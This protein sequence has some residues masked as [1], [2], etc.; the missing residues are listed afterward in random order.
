MNPQI[1][2]FTFFVMM[3]YATGSALKLD[4]AASPPSWGNGTHFHGVIDDQWNKSDSDQFANHHARTAAANLNVGEPYTVRV[5]YFI[6]NDREPGPNMDAKLDRLIKEIQQF[7]ADQM[8]A[9]GVGR[10]TFRFEADNAGNVVVHRVNGKYNDAYYQNPSTGSWIVWK[11]IEAQFDL[12]KNIYLLAL[13]I[14]NGFLNGNANAGIIGLG[15]GSSL[16]GQALIPASE[17]D[18]AAHELGH[19]F[20]LVHGDPSGTQIRTS[21]NIGDPMISSFCA[22]EWLDGHRYFNSSPNNDSNYDTDV[23]MLAPSLAAPPVSIRLRFE[24]ADPDGLHQAQ[25]KVPL[26]GDFVVTDCKRLSGKRTTVE[27]VTIRLIGVNTVGFNVMD[28][29]GNFLWREFPIDVASLLPPPEAI[30]I[31]DPNLAMAIRESVGIASSD[32]ITQL[33]MLSLVN[34]VAVNRGITDLTGIEGATNMAELHLWTN[35]I[36][37]ISAVA[38][39]TNLRVLHLAHNSISDISP[40]EGLT[41]LIN[42]ILAHNSISDISPVEGLTNLINLIL[43]GNSISD[44]SPLIANKGL[45]RGDMVN[46]VGNPLS[47]L[48]IH[49]HIP[50]LKERGVDINFDIQAHPALLKISGDNQNGAAFASLSQP[51]LVEAQDEN[52]SALPRISVTFAVARGGG[53]LSTTNAITDEN[54]RA[55]STLILGPNL[56]TNTVEVSATGIKSPAT[57]YAIADSELPPTTADVNSDG[58]V[59]VLD[60]ILIASSLGQS[61]QNDADVNGDKVVSVLGSGIGC[62]HV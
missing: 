32:A 15:T 61:G 51:F 30:S 38:G 35:S 27:F 26:S 11:E 7:Y 25:L 50:I 46:V 59:N 5:I 12:S 21:P 56:G 62:G 8:E 45:E 1:L 4:V 52:G 53:A 14:S 39:L 36:S 37:D 20:G 22:A 47:Y 60:L 43:D 54:G 10:K 23:E 29:H 6:P 58:L 34:C 19:G 18:G 44:L 24:V 9:H 17:F 42:L 33:T 13:D 31:P 41:N 2:R 28:A 57:F 48:S 3:I 55:Q 49:T 16:S 40:V